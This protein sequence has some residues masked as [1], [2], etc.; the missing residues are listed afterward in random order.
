MITSINLFFPL[1]F[2]VQ[3]TDAVDIHKF[4]SSIEIEFLDLLQIYQNVS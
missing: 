3:N 2:S 1:I 4:P